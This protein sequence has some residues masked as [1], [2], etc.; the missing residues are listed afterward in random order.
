MG[1]RL[2]D[3]GRLLEEG[4]VVVQRLLAGETVSSPPWDIEGA[5]IAPLPQRGTE[6]WIGAAV[7]AAID[8]AAR[9]GDCWY[10]GPELTPAAAAA[11]L[12]VYREA[13]ARHNRQPTRIPLRKDVFIADTMADAARVADPL[14]ATGYR[15]MD[16]SAIVYGD[17]DAVA[18]Q[19]AGYGDQGFTDVIIRILP[20]P[21][22]AMV[23]SVELAGEV[24]TRL[25]RQSR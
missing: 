1:A 15:G 8:R 12:S 7:P 3:R 24:Q 10:G 25:Q 5:R 16:R 20:A 19:L 6:W 14:L 18:E 22:D 9:F 13:C 4:L 23:R 2:R 17:P 11:A 21:L